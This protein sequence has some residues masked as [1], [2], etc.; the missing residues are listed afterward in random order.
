M[1]PLNSA[2]A[3]GLFVQMAE[4]FTDAG[5]VAMLLLIV[6]FDDIIRVA[7]PAIINAVAVER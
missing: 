5:M 1:R 7:P 3:F 4:R 2:F 6:A